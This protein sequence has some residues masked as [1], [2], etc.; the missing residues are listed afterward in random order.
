M[1]E[2][3]ESLARLLQAPSAKNTG[4]QPQL[5]LSQLHSLFAGLGKEVRG[6]Q[7]KGSA[8]KL[9]QG[10]HPG[11]YSSKRQQSNA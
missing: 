5:Y 2:H 4:H 8:M 6:V 1:K 10:Y 9:R 7:A 11:L 3:F